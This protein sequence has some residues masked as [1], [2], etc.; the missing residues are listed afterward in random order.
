MA[1]HVDA[2]RGSMFFLF[3]KD[4]KNCFTFFLF[5][6]F[7]NAGGSGGLDV[8]GMASGDSDAELVAIY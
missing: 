1:Y 3:A 2:S 7:Q 4:S 8:N 5:L 6:G